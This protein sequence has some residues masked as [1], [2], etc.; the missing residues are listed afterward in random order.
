MST[1]VIGPSKINGVLKAPPSKSCMQRACAAALIN[2]GISFIS[3]YGIS[4]DD[5]A[6]IEIIKQLGAIVEEKDAVLVIDARNF[7]KQNRQTQSSLKILCDESGLSLRMFTPIVAL[8]QQQAIIDGKGSLLQRPIHFFEDILPQLNVSIK[9]N[10][11]K[12]P[13]KIKGP[14]VTKN[15]AIDGALSSQFLTGLLFAFAY[16]NKEAVI[17]VTNLKSKPY[18]DLTLSVMKDFGLN[19]PKNNNYE[20]F[21]FSKQQLKLASD[22]KLEYEVE[23]DWSNAAFLLVAAAIAG[24]IV[25]KGLNANS[26]QADKAIIDVL[27][28]VGCNVIINE[29]TI[30][31]IKQEQALQCFTFDATH[32][33]DLFPPLVALA[34][35]CKGTSIIKGVS[36]LKHK[37]S[38]RAL[39]L[40]EE[41]KK[42]G[43]LI[44]ISADIMQVN[45]AAQIKG[46]IVNSHNDHRIAMACAIAALNASGKVSIENAEAIN[47]SYPNFYEDLEKIGAV[48]LR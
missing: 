44:N 11:S 19:I 6:A 20:E 24:N 26:T 2:G 7:N 10:Y 27:K 37:E 30:G 28:M 1:I 48:I 18:I 21:T 38:D 33:P 35:F 9:T 42:M 15:I 4:N 39:S 29:N 32:C 45:G 16:K 47:K 46:A 8:L 22:E 3:N 36:R 23:G 12:L 25:V 17:K 34:S 13:I 14:L 31:I 5:I 43:V 41:F 40:E